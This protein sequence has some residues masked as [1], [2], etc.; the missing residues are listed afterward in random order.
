VAIISCTSSLKRFFP[1]LKRQ[2]IQATTLLESIN[3]M[4]VHYPGFKDYILDEH[5]QLREFLNVYVDNQLLTDRQH[6]TLKVEGETNIYIAQAISG[7]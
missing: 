4:N 3:Q 2:E 6:L 1:T 7:G 5:E